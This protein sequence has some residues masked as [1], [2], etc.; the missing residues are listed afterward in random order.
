MAKDRMSV[1][2][3]H[4]PGDVMY[5]G[6]VGSERSDANWSSESSGQVRMVPGQGMTDH[7]I[8]L[9]DWVHLIRRYEKPRCEL[10]R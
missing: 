1:M 5:P 7:L 10:T 8:T 4:G 6:L 9:S 2:V 3:K